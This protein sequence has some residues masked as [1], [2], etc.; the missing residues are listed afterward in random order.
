MGSGGSIA[1]VGTTTAI[2]NGITTKGMSSSSSTSTYK[3]QSG[4]PPPQ[5]KNPEEYAIQVLF[6]EFAKTAEAKLAWALNFKLS[7]DPD[8]TTQLRAGA[9]AN[10]DRLLHT[11]GSLARQR[12]KAVV[13]ALMIW[14]KS[15]SDP[16][17]DVATLRA[18]A[19]GEPIS[20]E[21]LALVRERNSL[22]SI[23]ILCRALIEVVKQLKPEALADDLGVKLEEMVFNQ[24][25]TTDP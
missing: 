20:K 15:K 17:P 24:L 18:A 3:E 9:D 16:P 25:K 23:F 1:S 8:L 7:D 14:R 4:P 11:M 19:K 22:V 21:V 12:P 10:F 13:D 6:M 2:V 5:A